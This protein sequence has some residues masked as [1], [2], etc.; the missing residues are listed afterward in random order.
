M[1]KIKINNLTKND[2]SKK[3]SLKTGLP[4]S[5]TNEII[6]D[7]ISVLRILIKKKNFHIKNFASFKILNKGDRMGRNPKDNKPYKIKARKSLSFLSSKSL[8]NKI[9]NL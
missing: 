7:L 2:I 8:S 1:S 6:N 9:K 5:Y 3:I 4:A